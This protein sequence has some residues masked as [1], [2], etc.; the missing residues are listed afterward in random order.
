MSENQSGEQSFQIS[1]RSIVVK[2]VL[3]QQKKGKYAINASL[4]RQYEVDMLPSDFSIQFAQNAPVIETENVLTP[5]QLLASYFSLYANGSQNP[6]TAFLAGKGF[7]LKKKTGE[8]DKWW[9]VS[10]QI[11]CNLDGQ[12]VGCFLEQDSSGEI[13]TMH[14]DLVEGLPEGY[15]ASILVA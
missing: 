12:W 15:V 6:I 7:S 13:G 10:E 9:T 14:L 8:E 1:L 3:A 5:T 2:N 11:L 4:L